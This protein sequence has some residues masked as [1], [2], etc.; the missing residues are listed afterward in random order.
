[1][2]HLGALQLLLG[3][4]STPRLYAFCS[5]HFQQVLFRST[6]DA[7]IQTMQALRPAQACMYVCT[8]HIEMPMQTTVMH[9]QTWPTHHKADVEE[10][11]AAKSIGSE[12]HLSRLHGT[13][14][15]ASVS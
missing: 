6:S 14:Q 1:M 5:R 15:Q 8:V 9:Q 13:I 11:I 4:I 12:L 10:V 2:L 7:L 3:L